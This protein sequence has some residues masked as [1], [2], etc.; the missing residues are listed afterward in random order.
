LGILQN[1]SSGKVSDVT[2]NWD[3]GLLLY[4]MAIF[5]H[6]ARLFRI[7]NFWIIH[8]SQLTFSATSHLGNLYSQLVFN[9]HSAPLYIQ[10]TYAV[11][12]Y[13]THILRHFISRQ[14]TQSTGV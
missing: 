11:A 12:W 8:S 5:V 7:T 9:S 3:I 1:I 10:T 14:L 4:T 2:L 6:V 13:L